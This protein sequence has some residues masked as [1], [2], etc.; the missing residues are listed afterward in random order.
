MF[1]SK[2]LCEKLYKLTN[3]LPS[4]YLIGGWRWCLMRDGSWELLR[5]HDTEGILGDSEY[6]EFIKKAWFDGLPAYDLGYL[7]RKLPAFIQESRGQYPLRMSRTKADNY[8]YRFQYQAPTY[9]PR[10][11]C[12]D[13][14][15]ENA[16]I[17]L[18]IALVEQGVIKP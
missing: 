4:E 12:I 7:I 10:H 1:A 16:A 11:S 3:W 13:A 5:L 18:C 2:E 17:K 14:E 6:A 15:P 9:G 8:F